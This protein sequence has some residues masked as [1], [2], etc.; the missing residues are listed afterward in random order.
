MKNKKHDT[1]GTVTKSNRNIVERGKIDA[2]NTQIHD[3]SLSYLAQALKKK[4]IYGPKLI[5]HQYSVFTIV[6]I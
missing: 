6:Q 5:L 1:V 3:C 4:K 2:C